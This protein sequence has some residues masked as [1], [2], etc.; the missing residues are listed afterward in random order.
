MI[1]GVH[2]I[3]AQRIVGSSYVPLNK[4][5]Y[6]FKIM[7]ILGD[8]IFDLY[9]PGTLQQCKKW[10]RQINSCLPSQILESAI[11]TKELNDEDEDT[12]CEGK[13]IGFSAE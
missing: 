12:E 3:M 5:L 6:N 4:N 7:Y 9:Q 11:A 2:T 13:R 1:V 8:Q 10:S